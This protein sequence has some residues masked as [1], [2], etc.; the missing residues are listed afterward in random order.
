MHRTVNATLT[1]ANENATLTST[2][3]APPVAPLGALSFSLHKSLA[4]QNNGRE[5]W[6]YSRSTGASLTS[7][8]KSRGSSHDWLS[9]GASRAEA[10]GVHEF[11][12]GEGP[13]WLAKKRGDRLETISEDGTVA[14]VDPLRLTRWLFEES[15]EKGVQLHHP[16]TVDAIDTDSNSKM[17][18]LTIKYD[19]G[20]TAIVKSDRLVITSGPWSKLVFQKLFTKAKI[21]I[22]ISSLAGHSLV[23]RSPRWSAEHEDKGCHAVF[24]TDVDGF[25]P[26]IFSRIGGEIYLAG[27]ND[28]TLTLPKTGAEAKVDA[29]QINR[30]K[31][32]CRQM[33]GLSPGEE[34]DLEVLREGL[35]FRPV[36][37]T[38]SPIVTRISEEKLGGVRTQGGGDGGVFLCAGHGPWG[39][40]LSVGT[41]KV[42]SEMVEGVQTSADVRRLQLN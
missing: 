34:D 28:S 2:G 5:R 38:G 24:S 7:R 4:E 21:Q 17:V 35:C 22:P 9:S 41:G 40:S 16:A 14:Q 3:F 42:L 39:I 11:F 30:L 6:G 19:S 37:N 32:V 13:A 15:L 25:S 27:L 33:L 18:G 31:I 8:R 23:V 1:T 12:E 29:E 36:T 26:E 10:A 20:K